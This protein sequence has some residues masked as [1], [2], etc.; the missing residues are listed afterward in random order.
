MKL[1][2]K[3][4]LI[5]FIFYPL[6]INCKA[7]VG[8]NEESKNANIIKNKDFY[9]K[10]PENYNYKYTCS[11]N[12]K[13][14]FFLVSKDYFISKSNVTFQNK[15]VILDRRNLNLNYRSGS[16]KGLS[17][18]QTLKSIQF[19][20]ETLFPF[21]ENQKIIFDKTYSKKIN[22]FNN[23][24]SPTIK[25]L[26]KITPK[27]FNVFNNMNVLDAKIELIIGDTSLLN[28][29]FLDLKKVKGD[30]KIHL[31]SGFVLQSNFQINGKFETTSC[32]SNDKEI[33]ENKLIS[34]IVAS[35]DDQSICNN[36]KDKSYFTEGKLRNLNCS[37][38][39]NIT[40][41]PTYK[42]KFNNFSP[43]TNKENFK[44][45]KK[46]F[47]D[48]YNISTIVSEKE[49]TIEGTIVS[50]E[51]IDDFLINSHQIALNSENHFIYKL[52]IPHQG[53]K[54]NLEAA[55]ENGDK[56]IKE[57][58]VKRKDRNK[59]PKIIF[60]LLN[61]IKNKVKISQNA[62]ALIIGIEK[63]K[64]INGK[65][66]Y[67]DKDANMFRDYASEKLGIPNNN[68]KILLNEKAEY[69]EIILI[70]KNWLRRASKTNKSDIY[71]FFA[72][73]GLASDDGK[74]M[75]LLPYDGRSQL[76]DK[77]AL[78]R[79][80]LFKEIQ[81]SNPRSVTVFLDT[82]YSGA[83]RGTDMLITS[84]PIAI[85]ALKQSIPSNFTVFSAA[86]GNQTSKPLEEA[87]HGMFSYFLMK[88]MEGDAD[89]NNDNK[90][91]AQE[92]HNYV[93]KNVT[94]QSSGSQTPELQG[95]KDRVLVQFN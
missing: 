7:H 38:K 85:R 22:F 56:I 54:L 67:A 10:T 34:S 49:V 43:K 63:Y 2:I 9:F 30:V 89:T 5:L 94:Q 46:S 84:R 32:F 58:F 31:A 36:L 88:G 66:S 51:I 74:D 83:T 69:A 12:N 24:Y 78:L 65:A 37:F 41:L 40:S 45:S 87:K 68:I 17:K 48:F 6:L 70:T 76:L 11:L 47:I 15:D 16:I 42:D 25:A 14:S 80:E 28:L 75:Y 86:A 3:N 61:P 39:K 33:L 92:L 4:I 90:I 82:C 29:N 93:K 18:K 72:G 19:D 52:Y 60:D 73:H 95:D 91:T 20:Y 26:Y 55:N 27:K 8:Y 57:I 77:T 79:D 71:I 59:E 50:N 21:K 1:K 35:L 44:K 64:H 53:L 62:L 81:Q 23:S 13:D